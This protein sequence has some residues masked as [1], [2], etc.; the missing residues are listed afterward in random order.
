M[1]AVVAKLQGGAAT[2]LTT[3]PART[4]DVVKRM[5]NDEVAVLLVGLMPLLSL[6]GYLVSTYLCCC[7]FGCGSS[8]TMDVEKGGS[9][10]ASGGSSSNGHTSSVQSGEDVTV[11]WVRSL[12]D[13]QIDTLRADHKRQLGVLQSRLDETN[14]KLDRLLAAG[15]VGRPTGSTAAAVT[16]PASASVETGSSPP[17]QPALSSM[18]SS[19]SSKSGSSTPKGRS[20]VAGQGSSGTLKAGQG[21]GGPGSQSARSS[22]KV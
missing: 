5:T 3:L 22:A 4:W 1:E 20:P 18:S 14:T 13:K 16:S 2:L 9:G 7:F 10:D 19:N 21:K 11:D 15:G 6:L 12:V 8:S 17:R